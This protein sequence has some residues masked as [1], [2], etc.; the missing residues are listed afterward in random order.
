MNEMSSEH[1]LM[2]EEGQGQTTLDQLR[3]RI[4]DIMTVEDAQIDTVGRAIAFSGHLRVEAEVAFEKLKSRFQELGYIPLLRE[5]E[6]GQNQMILAI[7]GKVQAVL[8]QRPWL[9]LAL[10][11][12]TI[13]TTTIFGGAYAATLALQH[14]PNP[15]EVL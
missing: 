4:I 15:T 2:R 10:F 6:S 11:L 13:V 14:A 1:E 3:M 8:A 12:A 7:K 9:N 5:N